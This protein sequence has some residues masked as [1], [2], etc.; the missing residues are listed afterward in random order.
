M[1]KSSE[2]WLWNLI[3]AEV[4]GSIAAVSPRILRKKKYLFPANEI[5]IF[6]DFQRERINIKKKF[7]KVCKINRNYFFFAFLQ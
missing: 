1:E 7:W 3:G 6:S 2:A 5:D 4:C